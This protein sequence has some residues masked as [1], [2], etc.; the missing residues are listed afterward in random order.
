MCRVMHIRDFIH[1]PT[2]PTV[3][4]TYFKLLSNKRQALWGNSALPPNPATP[5]RGCLGSPGCKPWVSRQAKAVARLVMGCCMVLALALPAHAQ[6][7]EPQ[8]NSPKRLLEVAREYAKRQDWPKAV[9]TYKQIAKEPTLVGQVWPGYLEALRQTKDYPEAEKYLRRLSKATRRPEFTARLSLLYAEQGKGKEADRA[10][11]DAFEDCRTQDQAVQLSRFYEG[12]NKLPEA[13]E[14]L[15]LARKLSGEPLTWAYDLSQLY[16][17]QGKTDQMLDELFALAEK[18]PATLAEVQGMLQN[19]L[20]KK[21]QVEVFER[22]LLV[23][24]QNDPQNE[25]YGSMLYWLYLQEK[26]FDGAFIQAK[27]LDKRQAERGAYPARLMEVGQLARNSEAYGSAAEVYEYITAAYPGSPAA[28]AAKRQQLEMR[29]SQLESTYPVDRALATKLLSQYGALLKEAAPQ[30]QAG[31]YYEMGRLAGFYLGKS[32][33]AIQ[34]FE[35]AVATGRY[36]PDKAARAKLDLGDLYLLR[37]EP[38]EST[39]LYSQ[40]E[41]DNKDQPLGHEAKL[42]NARLSFYRGDF[43][44]AQEHLGVLKQATSREIANDALQLGLMISDNLVKD[45]TGKALRVYARAELLLLQTRYDDALRTLDS[46]PKVYKGDDLE[47]DVLNRKAEV[48]AQTHRFADAI[49]AYARLVESYPESIYA[50]DALYQEA[51]MTEE[52]LKDKPAAMALYERL[53]KEQPG[54][55][56][57]ADARKRYRALRGDGV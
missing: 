45:T 7:P 57:V 51:V 21:E 20:E 50:D 10:K 49:T 28:F 30:E 16:G 17:R 35:R 38:W 2:A 9:E 37:G 53:L 56:F 47:D 8:D 3:T 25:T 13:T 24:L 31:L 32:D 5:V 26:D 36:N 48:Y 12:Q 15:L 18:D 55:V 11:K 34:L 22:R 6:R 27:A 19:G 54:S 14:A 41:K 42:R 44:L 52:R 33:S 4:M 1:I 40:V 29:R 46:I 23:K 39:L 43:L